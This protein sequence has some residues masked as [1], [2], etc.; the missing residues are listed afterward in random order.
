MYKGVTGTQRFNVCVT[1]WGLVGPST[2]AVGSSVQWS[3]QE[4]YSCAADMFRFTLVQWTSRDPSVATVKS[5]GLNNDI[6]FQA[7]VTGVSVGT[8]TIVGVGRIGNEERLAQITVLP[9]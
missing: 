7:N 9:R 8:A 1:S 5:V 4:I 3:G 2:V 6:G